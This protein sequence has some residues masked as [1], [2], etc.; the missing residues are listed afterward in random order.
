MS[1][2]EDRFV[3]VN[4]LRLHYLD[5]GNPTAQP[6]LLLH[7]TASHAHVWD[8]FAE[9]MSSEYHV[10]AV[11]QRG[12][13]D[14]ESPSDYLTGYAQ[15][16]WAADILGVI[17]ALDL[18]RVV[19]IGLSTGGNNA[20]HFTARHPEDIERLVVVDMGPEVLRAGA[21]RV[22]QAKPAQ[23]EFDSLEEGI[24]Q[25]SAS[26]R[27]A[28]PELGR[29]HAFHHLRPLGDGRYALK[30]DPALRNPRWRRPL[31]T[32]EENW[33][34]VRAIRVPTL[35]MRGGVSNMISDEI[36]N[37]VQQEMTNCTYVTVEGA[38]HSVPMHQ[39]EGFEAAIRAW[40][41]TPVS[42]STGADAGGATT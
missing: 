36:A 20:T 30:G 41:A 27:R 39:P 7:G 3:E 19:L 2:A 16:H 26:N 34:A 12:H 31:R 40:L 11:D 22:I 9:A 38:G 4:G 17:T 6:M 28:V 18:H 21:D 37:R 42:A 23:E 5:W 29:A 35:L 14:S 10:I 24:E 15:E 32:S 8:R 1:H 33:A 13:G 25:L